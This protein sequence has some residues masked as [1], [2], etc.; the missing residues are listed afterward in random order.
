M[1]RQ[2]QG[3]SLADQTARTEVV[4]LGSL[5]M[6]LSV[7]VR[8]LPKP[9]E[10]ILAETVS[11]HPGG[12]GANQAVAAARLGGDVHLV[13]R[14]GQDELADRIRAALTD[15]GVNLDHVRATDRA[16]GQAFVTVDAQ[17]ENVI[18][19]ASGANADVTPAAV[20]QEADVLRSA[21]IAVTQL[22]T[23]LDAVLRFAQLCNEF[24]VDLI[25]NAA[26][27]RS[28]PGG[29]LRRCRYLVLNRDEAR[30][31]TRI[32]VEDRASAVDAALEASRQGAD[33]VV[34]TLGGLG[35]VAL[36]DGHVVEL[37]AYQVPVTDTT[38]AG[39]AFVGALAVGLSGGS[40]F[41]EALRFAAA[42]GATACAAMGA[43]SLTSPRETRR[44]LEEQPHVL[45]HRLAPDLHHTTIALDN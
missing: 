28:L 29:L 24:D 42:A 43:Q 37:D 19:V 6:D 27:Y 38:G 15:T 40:N 45:R 14:L 10:T 44:L 33:R 12:K 23:P 25:L 31:L 22:E 36:A 8:Q 2:H 32:A 3:V 39:D 4:V 1:T 13:G 35:C 34:I 20:Q 5:N 17:G 9:G 7:T 26:P 16:T 41:D 30:A 21:R 18:V 11:Q